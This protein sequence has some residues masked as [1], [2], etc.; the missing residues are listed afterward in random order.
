MG[1]M[2]N[3]N[4]KQSVKIKKLTLQLIFVLIFTIISFIIVALGELQM[5]DLLTDQANL[6][7]YA[8]QYR[9]GSKNLTNA[10]RCYAATGEQQ[11]YDAYYDE[12]NQDK[13]RDIAL[14]GMFAIGI[15]DKE[16]SY[17]DQISNYSNGLVP[18]EEE[19]MQH[20]QDNNLAAAVESV[21]GPDYENTIK[22]IN[23][24]TE[25]MITTLEARVIREVNNNKSSLIACNVFFIITIILVIVTAIRILSFVGKELLKPVIEVQQQME[26]ISNGVLNAPFGIEENESE[27]GRMAASIHRTKHNLTSMIGEVS[28]VLT[29][30]ASGNFDQTLKEEYVGEFISIHQ[31]FTKILTD[32]NSSFHTV[33]SATEYVR[34]GSDQMAA[35]A[36]SLADG[37]MEQTKSI[38][39]IGDAVDNME[40]KIN[41]TAQNSL[42]SVKQIEEAG[43]S[44]EEGTKNMKF[45]KDIITEMSIN[46][47]Q[48][49]GIIKSIED[50]AFQTN[51]LAL[52]AAIEAARAGVAG[53]GFAV[54]ADEVKSLA[55][56]SQNSAKDT[57]ALIEKTIKM[58]QDGTTY[59]DLTAGSLTKVQ[60]ATSKSIS[61]MEEISQQTQK[62]T[63]L[64]KRVKDSINLVSVVVETNSAAAQQM[65]ASSEEQNAQAMLLSETVSHFQLSSLNESRS[66]ANQ[67]HLE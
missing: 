57:A 29:N 54:V 60:A 10:V 3:K 43:H 53:K 52:N 41:Q 66:K 32:L 13:N 59:A 15:T 45:L 47:S 62:Q 17:I 35:A 34:S 5:Q 1:G 49:N 46:S 8:N 51:I 48:I 37:T 40:E 2:K 16:Q 21:F 42:L 27:I 38:T 14:E 36:Q 4:A 23:G 33:R 30:M 50:I 25:D 7:K 24:L 39:E 31:S 63:E 67:Y 20:V 28:Q 58:I 11:F 9:I 65:A 19:A 18:L 26:K 64:A 61:M 6:I 12:L 22:E 44:L 56:A 55:S